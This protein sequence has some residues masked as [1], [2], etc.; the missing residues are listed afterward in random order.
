LHGNGQL[1]AGRNYTVGK[2]IQAFRRRNLFLCPPCGRYLGHKWNAAEDQKL[3]GRMCL[4]CYVI[5]NCTTI[6]QMEFIKQIGCWHIKLAGVEETIRASDYSIKNPLGKA[7]GREYHNPFDL[8]DFLGRMQI[9][10]KTTS[11]ASSIKRDYLRDWW[12]DSGFFV[13]GRKDESVPEERVDLEWCFY[14]SMVVGIP[15]LPTT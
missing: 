7:S 1:D 9:T 5:L 12:T 2:V 11:T 14:S 6:E 4:D 15:N 8:P 10:S 3:G 13:P